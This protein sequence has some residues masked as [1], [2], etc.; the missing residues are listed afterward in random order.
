MHLAQPGALLSARN[1]AN[2]SVFHGPGIDA[3]VQGG[4]SLWLSTPAAIEQ[5]SRDWQSKGSVIDTSTG[6]RLG[7]REE[8]QGEKKYHSRGLCTTH[9]A[10]RETAGLQVH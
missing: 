5:A 10:H 7:L 9:L 1:A 4:R 6:T 2:I 8:V 3:P